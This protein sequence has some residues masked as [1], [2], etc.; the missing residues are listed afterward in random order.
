MQHNVGVGVTGQPA[1][2]LNRNPAEDQ[3]VSDFEAVGVVAGA[4]AVHCHFQ[5]SRETSV[6]RGGSV[7]EK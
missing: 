3:W 4:D 1:R 6:E 7:G 2:M 5:I